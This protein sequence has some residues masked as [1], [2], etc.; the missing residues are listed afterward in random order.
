VRIE[1]LGAFHGIAETA[2]HSMFSSADLKP[3]LVQR[4][5]RRHGSGLCG[6]ATRPR[7]SVVVL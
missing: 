2:W 3:M 7:D 5:P 6:D 1:S 4:F